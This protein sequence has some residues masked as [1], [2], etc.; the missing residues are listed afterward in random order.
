MNSFVRKWGKE[1]DTESKKQNL[2]DEHGV[3]TPAILPSKRPLK[4]FAEASF[5]AKSTEFNP[6]GP[7][8]DNLDPGTHIVMAVF[9]VVIYEMNQCAATMSP[10][11]V[12]T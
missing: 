12:S 9:G 7:L 8:Q 4:E 11:N 10:T 5:R 1:C 2:K 3:V 6:C